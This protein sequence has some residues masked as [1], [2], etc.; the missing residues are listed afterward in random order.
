MVALAAQFVVD[1]MT[2]LPTFFNVWTARTLW[3]SQGV[4]KL[5]NQN[6]EE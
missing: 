4:Q 5:M 1:L 2:R 3:L 6:I